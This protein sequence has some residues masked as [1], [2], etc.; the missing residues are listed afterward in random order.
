MT[1]LGLAR[2][3][4]PRVHGGVSYDLELDTSAETAEQ[5]AA[6]IKRRFGL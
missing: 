4:Y 1:V 3:Q 6:R 2:W 5:L